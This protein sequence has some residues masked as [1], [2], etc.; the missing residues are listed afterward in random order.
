MPKG[1]GPGPSVKDPEVHEKLRDE[2]ALK[3]RAARIANAAAAEGRSEV[4]KRGGE[5]G[6]YEDPTVEEPRIRVKELGLSG[7]SGKEKSELID[8]LRNH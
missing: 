7:H 4:G 3:E 1:K 5:A 2:G 6:D 8:M